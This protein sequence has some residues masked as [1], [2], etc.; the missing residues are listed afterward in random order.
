MHE[1]LPLTQ[2]GSLPVDR[3]LLIVEDEQAYL[4][5]LMQ[6]MQIRGFDVSGTRSV[7]DAIRLIR[8]KPPSFAVVELRLGRDNG[9]SVIAEL[10][11]RHPTARAVVL[12]A[13]DNLTT[14]VMAI[15][16]GAVDYLAKP[17][18]ADE[19]SNVLLGPRVPSAPSSMEFMTATRVRWE[20]I[21]RVF[22][23]CDHNVS[24][25]A[26]RLEMHRRTLQRMLAKR[27]PK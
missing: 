9:L 13:F 12:T 27:A 1:D 7:S 17:V 11:R 4:R 10:S 16:L 21:Q 15:K 6:A 19:L 5:R 25:T 23:L 22:E 20:H 14:A 24:D 2:D 3:S 26:R 8:N 18:N